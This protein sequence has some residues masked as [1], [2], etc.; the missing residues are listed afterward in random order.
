MGSQDQHREVVVGQ[1]EQP[2]SWDFQSS[3]QQLHLF[4]T[5]NIPGYSP[6]SYARPADAES[7]HGTQ[8]GDTSN[9]T[10]EQGWQV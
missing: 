2:K 7:V 3:N 8:Q 1:V 6:A 5:S 10:D 9:A 4:A